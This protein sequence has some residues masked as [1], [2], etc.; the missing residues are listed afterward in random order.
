MTRAIS[1]DTTFGRVIVTLVAALMLVIAARSAMAHHG[2]SE[3]DADKRATIT[4][5]ISELHFGNPH[6]TIV[7]KTEDKV[8]NVM[9]AA[10]SRLMSRG[11]TAEMLAVGR[12]V[13]VEGLPHKTKE[14]EFRAERMTL[15][16]K[17]IELR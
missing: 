13:T 4:G 7:L 2:W 8:W 3:Y 5:T 12:A 14:D 11:C 16:G 17:T 15:D 10:P 9:L 1:I 6:V